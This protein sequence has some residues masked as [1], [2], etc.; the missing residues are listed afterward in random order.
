M[1]ASACSP[2]SRA[3][4]SR[5][6]RGRAAA[7]QRCCVHKLRN[8]DRIVYAASAEAARAADIAFERTWAKRRSG[9]A[10]V[11]LLFSLAASGQ[12]KLRKID[13]RRKIAAVHSQ[14]TVTAA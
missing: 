2:W 13:G 10:A 14:H 9:V 3:E 1:D 4:A 12:I 7:V 5:S 6:R 11:V 8:I